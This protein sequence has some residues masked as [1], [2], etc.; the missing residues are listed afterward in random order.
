MIVM[1]EL[2]K[3]VVM[4]KENVKMKLEVNYCF[5]YKKLFMTSFHEFTI[6]KVLS[7]KF[8]EF[9]NVSQTLTV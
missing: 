1:T 7:P 9:I 3:K 2:M 6:L 5:F 8:Y 4:K